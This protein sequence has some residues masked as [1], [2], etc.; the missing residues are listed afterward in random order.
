MKGLAMR[1]RDK[2]RLSTIG[3]GYLL[4]AENMGED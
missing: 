1:A 2:T 4:A 3:Q